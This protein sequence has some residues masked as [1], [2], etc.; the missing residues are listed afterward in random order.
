MSGGSGYAAIFW[1]GD[2][3][4]LINELPNDFEVLV[5]NGSYSGSYSGCYSGAALAVAT[6]VAARQLCGDFRRNCFAWT[7]QKEVVVDDCAIGLKKEP[8]KALPDLDPD[9]EES[10]ISQRTREVE[11]QDDEKHK[12][13]ED[14][15]EQPEPG[16]L[17]DGLLICQDRKPC[18]DRNPDEDR[19]HIAEERDNQRQIC[20]EKHPFEDDSRQDMYKSI[21]D[22][23]T[24]KS[25]ALTMTETEAILQ[26]NQFG[27]RRNGM[28]ENEQDCVFD[29][30]AP[31]GPSQTVT[32]TSR[33]IDRLSDITD[34]MRIPGSLSIKVAEIGESGRGSFVANLTIDFKDGLEYKL[35]NCTDK[36]KFAKAYGDFFNSG[37]LKGGKVN[38][39][40]SMKILNKAKKTD[41]QTEAKV[42]FTVGPMSVEAK[43][44]AGIGRENIESNTEIAF[45]TVPEE[46]ITLIKYG[47]L[48]SFVTR[49]PKAYSRLQ[50]ESAQIVQQ[51]FRTCDL[52]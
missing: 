36:G 43:A 38:A 33:F 31:L 40:I 48:W 29:P 19:R 46:P 45:Q 7:R 52:I 34:D 24:A 15:Q 5:T 4:L 28:S 14:D 41:I 23:A 13:L 39:A 10:E 37:F 12:D 32:Y 9:F 50:Y 44:N 8:L 25:T 1:H 3:R 22:A 49:Q 20:E 6:T 27:D 42:A 2:V 35:M 51:C 30:N 47:N 16:P 18:E 21:K 26:Q 11:A 17:V